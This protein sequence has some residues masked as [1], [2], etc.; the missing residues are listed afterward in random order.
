L[1]A[2][3]FEGFGLS[4]NLIR[5]LRRTEL[6]R[7]TPIQSQSLPLLLD[8]ADLMAL[9]QTGTGKT[10]AFLLPMLHRLHAS[11]T[12]RGS[13]KGPRGLV[14]APTRELAL[15]IAAAVEVL[16]SETGLRHTVIIGGVEARRQIRSVQA[17]ADIL[18]AT[19]GRLADLAGDGRI[20]LG[21]I[22][23]FVLDEADRMLDMGFIRDIR[24]IG[25]FLPD[26][27]QSLLFSATMPAEIERLAAQFLRSPR[28]IEIAPGAPAVDRIDQQ[29]HY[30]EAG[31]KLEVLRDLLDRPEA[32]RVIV[33]VR[34]KRGADRLTRRLSDRGVH[35]AA[36]H[37]DKSLAARRRSLEAFRT[38]K[39]RVLI[40]TD[41]VARG[42][43]VREVSHVINF[44]MPHDPDS[45]VH[46]I[47]RT[48]RAGADG[49]A[50]SLCAADERGHLADIE[51]RLRRKLTVIQRCESPPPPRASARPAGSVRRRAA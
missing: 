13:C 28:R 18:V 4:E 39:S 2:L 24:R 7:P 12:S 11:K 15:Q 6:R 9:S 38:G 36:I 27:R 51:R 20:S 14:L 40:A 19:P 31:E 30:A 8:G 16:A 29:L 3:S 26:S 49:V 22:E 5:A 33:F 47:G 50:I 21:H 25:R 43:D 45:Y 35:A 42:I 10:A 23:Y 34:T 46:R 1:N 41:V 32:S 44:D 48:A 37:G 17:G